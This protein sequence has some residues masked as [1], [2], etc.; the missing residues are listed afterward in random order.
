MTQNVAERAEKARDLKAQISELSAE[1]A[2]EILFL[3][4]SPGR[5][6]VTIYRSDTGEPVPVPEYM[7]KN[8][9]GNRLQDG[10]FAFVAKKEDAPVYQPG[11]AKCFLHADS[12][13]REDL[14]ELGLS[15]ITCPAGNLANLHSKRVHGQRRHKQE[16]AALQELVKDRKEAKQEARQQEQLDATLALAG[17]AATV[18]TPVEVAA[19]GTC[20]ICHKTGFKNVGVHKSHVHKEA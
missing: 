20:D 3:E 2:G 11:T 17:K 15:G 1:D 19:N 9:M 16:W 13:E 4:I 5:V 18:A 12:P 14:K 8:V 6:P 10:R 7:V